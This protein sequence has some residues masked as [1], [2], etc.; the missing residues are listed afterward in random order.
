METVQRV[1]G[2]VVSARVQPASRLKNLKRPMNSP[3][4]VYPTALELTPTSS[5]RIVWS[6]GRDGTISL[7][8]LRQA[9]PCAHC[10]QQN[11]EERQ[12]QSPVLPA[13][14]KGVLP[15]LTPAQARPLSIESMQPVGQYAY[16]I[17]FSDGHH[18]GIFTFEL[19]RALSE[20]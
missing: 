20:A 11:S 16:G 10:R 13:A 2:V 18:G 6:D 9:C 1:P 19:L 14:G 17:A 12:P 8:R 4:P 7:R 3:P 15:I 5:L